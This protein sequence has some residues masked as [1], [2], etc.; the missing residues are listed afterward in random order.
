MGVSSARRQVEDATLSLYADDTLLSRVLSSHFI[1]QC[2]LVSRFDVCIV[3]CSLSA[4][5]FW[6]NLLFSFIH[7]KNFGANC[8]WAEKFSDW[9]RRRAAE[10]QNWKVKP[11]QQR[12]GECSGEAP[13]KVQK[14]KKHFAKTKHSWF[15]YFH[16]DGCRV[17]HQEEKKSKEVDKEAV[18]IKHETSPRKEK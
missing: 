7:F 18:K 14:S 1:N 9:P 4:S 2:Y 13:V 15:S 17:K 16:T 5:L 6:L 10:V 11:V 12:T 8:Q 3:L